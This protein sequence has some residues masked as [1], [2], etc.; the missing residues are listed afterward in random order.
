MNLTN[1][2]RET[3]VETLDG[4]LSLLEVGQVVEVR[5]L[6]GLLE[7]VSTVHNL[8]GERGV[9]EDVAVDAERFLS[10][11]RVD[12]DVEHGEGE[13]EH[14][15]DAPDLSVGINGSTTTDARVVLNEDGA[16][17]GHPGLDVE[18]TGVEAKAAGHGSSV[19]DHLF[20]DLTRGEGGSNA[21]ELLVCVRECLEV[22][23]YVGVHKLAL[24]ENN[25][26][27]ELVDATTVD[28]REHTGLCHDGSLALNGAVVVLEAPAGVNVSEDTLEG[29]AEL[30]IVIDTVD[31]G[32][33]HS[34][35]GLDDHGEANLAGGDLGVVDV[36]DLHG[37]DRVNVGLA[38]SL[39]S[40]ELVASNFVGLRGV[41]GKLEK[42][43]NAAHEEYDGFVG[44][45]HAIEGE[46]SLADDGNGVLSTV[47]GAKICEE[48]GIDGCA[49]VL[50][51]LGLLVLLE[52]R[53]DLQSVCAK[54]LEVIAEK[55]GAR[56]VNEVSS[57]KEHVL[58]LERGEASALGLVIGG[59][60]LEK[61]LDALRGEVVHLGC[62][63]GGELENHP[64]VSFYLLLL[65]MLLID[66]NY[67]SR[68]TFGVCWS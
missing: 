44:G 51:V 54:S 40:A 39:A 41:A 9:G 33:A 11:G 20:L 34:G 47:L 18:G 53:C 45:P 32:A 21:A 6:P 61:L 35:R 60:H 31:T 27:V 67:T 7:E 25:L 10:A 68:V 57:H 14:G 56:R 48:L 22:V 1:P 2:V 30:C 52:N 63:T 19:L 58:A 37:L 23:E 42:L 5:G 59:I 38:E 26:N 62:L 24:V 65:L 29:V 49:A 4:L 28:V 46:S 15:V 55:L 3:G 50:V 8:T 64:A 13:L 36:P 16:S 43:G 66:L 17:R 12:G